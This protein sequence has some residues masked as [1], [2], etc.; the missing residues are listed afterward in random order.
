MVEVEKVEVGAGAVHR[1]VVELAR[2]SESRAG[3]ER[4][5]ARATNLSPSA[6]R[7]IRAWASSLCAGTLVRLCSAESSAFTFRCSSRSDRAARSMHSNLAVLAVLLDL[8]FES[9]EPVHRQSFRPLSSILGVWNERASKS[10]IGAV[11]PDLARALRRALSGGRSGGDERGCTASAL[12]AAL[13]R[14]R[15]RSTRRKP[16]LGEATGPGERRARREDGRE[17]GCL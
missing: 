11:L 8:T 3:G 13:S 7:R 6:D 4:G 15:R 12:G 5:A 16:R 1:R 17:D 9:I 10:L 2:E 14:T